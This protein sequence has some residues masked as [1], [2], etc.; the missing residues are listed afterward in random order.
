MRIEAQ[1]FEHKGLCYTIR[2]AVHEDAG[3]L[4]ALRLQVDGETEYLDRVPGEGFMDPE[5][6]AA[7]IAEDTHYSR[8][9]CLVADVQG[10]LAGFARCEGS[11]L[12]RLAHRAEFGVGVL[13]EFWGYGI[14]RSLLQ[15]AV[16]WADQERLEKLSL[17]VLET[18][19]KAIRLYHSLGFEVEG[20]L[21]RD[22]RLADGQFYNTVV[23]GRLRPGG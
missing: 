18:N 3:L 7:L 9:L 23:M 13:R 10:R 1:T 21:R 2:S 17:Q 8:N 16:C 19:D 4:S 6:W 12:L 22:K 15:Q 14:G 20:V 11:E 5:A